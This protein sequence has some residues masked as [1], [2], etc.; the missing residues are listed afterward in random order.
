ML[1]TGLSW[2]KLW[3]PLL[4][5]FDHLL[6]IY[7]PRWVTGS[8]MESDNEFSR[9]LLCLGFRS[10]ACMSIEIMVISG[11]WGVSGKVDRYQEAVSV[12]SLHLGV[13]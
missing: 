12:R 5:S 8:R 3:E 7:A 2:S 11:E 6:L 9:L 1:Q 10:R 13:I 4:L